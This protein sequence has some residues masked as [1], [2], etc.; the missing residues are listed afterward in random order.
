MTLTDMFCGSGVWGKRMELD[1]NQ[2]ISQM[3]RLLIS[4]FLSTFQRVTSLIFKTI[5]QT[6]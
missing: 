3:R 6:K 4:D 5:F 2:R 1:R